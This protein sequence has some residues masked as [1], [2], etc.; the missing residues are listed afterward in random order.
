MEKIRDKSLTTFH[1]LLVCW[2]RPRSFS[3]LALE[4]SRDRP[5]VN[6]A[7]GSLTFRHAFGGNIQQVRTLNLCVMGWPCCVKAQDPRTSSARNLLLG[8]ECT[9][10]LRNSPR[11]FFQIWY[12]QLSWI[13]QFIYMKKRKLVLAKDL[14]HQVL[15]RD[16]MCILWLIH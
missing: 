7:A 14:K 13:I 1:R 10:T 15:N 12:I 9:P 8:A 5:C 16:A 11:H 4:S 2:H 6:D 3:D